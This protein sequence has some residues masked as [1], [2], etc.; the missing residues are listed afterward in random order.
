MTDSEHQSRFPVTPSWWEPLIE[1]SAADGVNGNQSDNSAEESGAA[2]V[3][4]RSGNTWSQQAYLK[5][6]N[7]E[8]DDRFG[9]TVTISGNTIVV[10]APREDSDADGV[11][12]DQDDNSAE[13]SGAAY[14]FVRS[15][16]TWSQQAYLKASN[17][18]G[19]EFSGDLFGISVAI[20]GDTI[21]VGARREDSDADGVNGDQDDN[22]AQGSGAAYVFV[23]S[24]STW[25]QQAYLKASNSDR[26]DDLFE[27]PSRFRGTPSWRALVPK[28]AMPL[29]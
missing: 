19:G 6:S 17:S 18:E 10:G 11:N 22:S 28:R 24:G 14:V 15:G 1:D 8:A 27:N 9:E 25:S 16:I 4:V 23:R 2:Y 7:S 26:S 29:E 21:V 20:S 12:G 3:F 13:D 5:A